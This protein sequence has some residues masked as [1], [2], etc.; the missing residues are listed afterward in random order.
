MAL[1]VQVSAVTAL[2]V[3]GSK[4]R[5]LYEGRGEDKKP[6]GRMTDL[7]GRPVSAV[8]A[9]VWCVPLGMLADVTV[10][11]PDMQA[12]ALVPGAIVQV[13]GSTMARLAGAEYAAIR[14][15]ITGERVTPIGVWSEW[16]ANATRGGK[17]AD[18]TAA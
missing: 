8:S 3:S 4:E 12:K 18:R 17:P 1:E 14:S 6:K 2:V 7:E 10:L 11:L 9:V 16:V 13:E 5:Q 15:T